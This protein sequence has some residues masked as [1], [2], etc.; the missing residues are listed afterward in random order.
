[1]LKSGEMI[2]TLLIPNWDNLSLRLMVG[3][4]QRE[5]V[6]ARLMEQDKSS[7]QKSMRFNSG[8][9]I[10]LNIVAQQA[11]DYVKKNGLDPSKTLLWMIESSLAC[12][13]S[14]FCHHIRCIFKQYGSGM[15]KTGVYDGIMSFGDFSIKLPVDA[16]LSYMFGG[17]IRKIGCRLRPYEKIKGKTDAAIEKSIEIL[18]G[19]FYGNHSKLDALEKIVPLFKDIDIKNEY[20]PKVAI[21]GDLYVR[22]NEMMNQDLIHFIE[23]HGGEVVTTPYSSYAKMVAGQYLR[24]W[25]VEGRYKSCFLYKSHDRSV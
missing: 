14:M 3:A 18:S 22:D 9:C 7:I 20:R 11:I 8:Q 10:P 6:D 25:F 1:M 21:F 19:A 15:E 13:L 12:N 24:K 4:L 17:L 5:G 16:Y 2:K 23:E